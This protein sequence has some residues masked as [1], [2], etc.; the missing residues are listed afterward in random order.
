MIQGG[1]IKRVLLIIFCVLVLIIIIATPFILKAK[2]E[3]EKMVAAYQKATEE[4]FKEADIEIESVMIP[5]HFQIINPLKALKLIKMIPSRVKTEKLSTVTSMNAT[6]FGFMKMYTLLLAPETGYN[7]PI[8]SFDIVFMGKK[9][10][11]VIEVI[12]PSHIPADYLTN[13]YMKMSALKEKVKHLPDTPPDMPWA[14]E[15]TMSFSIHTKSD[16]N[17]D[18]LFMNLF[19]EYL[20]AYLV[21]VK[22]APSLASEE[23]SRKVREGIERY[24]NTLLEK[25]GPAVNVFKFLLGPEKQKEFV[26][27]IMFGLEK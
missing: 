13:A 11:F 25:G 8:F 10:V 21:M 18:E 16:R 15:M 17:Q 3:G 22:E 27:R 19:R 7:L 6:M 9:R 12:D 23:E 24:V 14:K 26:K 4:V 5:T 2:A 20:T 1:F